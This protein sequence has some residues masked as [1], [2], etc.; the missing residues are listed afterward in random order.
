MKTSLC[1]AFDSFQQ[2]QHRVEAG[3]GHRSVG[4]AFERGA[5]EAPQFVGTHVRGEERLP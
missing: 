3:R 1:F 4:V 2:R 5:V